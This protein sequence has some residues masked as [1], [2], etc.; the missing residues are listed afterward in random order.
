MIVPG[1]YFCTISVL[2][3]FLFGEM[4]GRRNCSRTVCLETRM[5]HQR[6]E[7]EII[8]G[9]G[10]VLRVLLRFIPRAHYRTHPDKTFQHSMSK[11]NTIFH[12]LYTGKGNVHAVF[13]KIIRNKMTH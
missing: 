9:L 12:H 11:I 5:F 2:Q 8:E 6:D 13:R 10:C 1:F 7:T 4:Q 3:I